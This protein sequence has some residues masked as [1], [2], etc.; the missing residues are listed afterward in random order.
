[1]IPPRI[2]LAICSLLLRSD[3]RLV[4]KVLVLQGVFSLG[5]GLSA[6][7]VVMTDCSVPTLLSLATLCRILV[8]II[9]LNE[10]KKNIRGA[11]VS[12]SIAPAGRL[13]AY[14][15]QLR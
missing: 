3:P 15:M 13:L 8:P 9:L 2:P 10:L 4:F 14:D 7:L 12:D 6:S 1:M 5:Y 11:H